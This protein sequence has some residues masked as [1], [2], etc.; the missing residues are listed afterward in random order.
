MYPPSWDSKGRKKVSWNL[1]N[2]SVVVFFSKI[3]REDL[4]IMSNKDK[5]MD[6]QVKLTVYLKLNMI[7]LTRYYRRYYV[8]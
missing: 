7:H 5:N 6:D 1:L 8:N 2:L 4:K 3:F